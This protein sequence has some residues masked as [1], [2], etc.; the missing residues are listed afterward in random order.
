MLDLCC[1]IVYFLKMLSISRE[2]KEIYISVLDTGLRVCR[3][4]YVHG[5]WGCGL[6]DFKWKF[7]RRQRGINFIKGHKPTKSKQKKM[8]KLLGSF[9]LI[10]L[11]WYFYTLQ[12]YVLEV[13]NLFG[14]IHFTAGKELTSG[15]IISQ[16]P[17]IP[18]LDAIQKR[19][20]TSDFRVDV[21]WV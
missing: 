13:H 12:F 20:W 6:A 18:D 1:I 4:H 19:L 14:F 9:T 7:S 2:R 8:G 21:E 5:S 16:V 15:R 10:L 3:I 11:F 17:P